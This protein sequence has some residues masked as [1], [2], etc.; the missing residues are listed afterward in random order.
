M[1][2]RSRTKKPS[3]RS[4]IRANAPINGVMIV[5]PTDSQQVIREQVQA[6][7]HRCKENMDPAERDRLQADVT[8][9]RNTL[10]QHTR[11]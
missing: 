10:L 9:F 1:K 2:P 5:P 11:S 7:I 6:H 4:T 3:V 8:A